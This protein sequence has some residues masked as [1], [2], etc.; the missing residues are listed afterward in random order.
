M[1]LQKGGLIPM[2]G[3]QASDRGGGSGVKP[4]E[5]FSS[6]TLNACSM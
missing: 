6:F 2:A 1:I 4:L 5:K 3:V